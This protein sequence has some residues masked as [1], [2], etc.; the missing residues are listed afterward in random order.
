M[1]T[2]RGRIFGG[3]AAALCAATLCACSSG[4]GGGSE[5]SAAFVPADISDIATITGPQFAAR[6]TVGWNLGNTLDACDKDNPD[7]SNKGLS[8]ETSWGMPETTEAMI[9]ALPA[10]GF[11]TI[12]IPV[13]WHNHMTDANYTIDAD[14]M[15]RVKKIVD[16]SLD[17]GLFVIIN[18]HHDNLTEE[19]MASTYGFC[20]PEDSSS[21]LK[22]TSLNYIK[23]VWRQV[24]AAFKDT[25]E[26]LVFEALNEPRCIGKSYEWSA[27]GDEDK[28]K[29]SAANAIIR[30]YEA[31]AIAEIRAAGGKN[32]TRFIMVPPF[33]A[34]PSMMDGWSLP[35]DS[36]NRLLVSVHA[37][38]PYG[39]AMY[40]SSDPN[41]TTFTS[42]DE[43]SHSWLFETAL[44]SW[45]STGVVVGEASATDKR[46][47]S[48]RVKWAA[49]YF[50]KAKAAGVPVLLW[51]NMKTY[52]EG[53]DKGEF[54]GWFNRNNLS[55]YFPSVVN[56][57]LR[58]AGA[59]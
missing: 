10:K 29:V 51:D 49:S 53:G 44:K 59:M 52:E 1:G 56:E 40:D 48:E 57:M 58:Q 4:D 18:I 35:S 32:A 55:W 54:H 33:A 7:K 50:G 42:S 43:S 13:S 17:A 26:R 41:H 9:K 24:A 12:R 23:T 31:A 37:Y 39:F 15:A 46:N 5:A 47:E 14:W 11:R 3:I 19:K 38:T 6:M 2:L 16:W 22:T 20:V 8:T 25:D 21:A 45:L 36:A 34:S 30:E 28:Q 27:S